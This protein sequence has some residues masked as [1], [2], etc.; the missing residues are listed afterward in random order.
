LRIAVPVAATF[1]MSFATREMQKARRVNSRLKFV[2][3]LKFDDS[4]T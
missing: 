2:G 1:F 4:G 3:G